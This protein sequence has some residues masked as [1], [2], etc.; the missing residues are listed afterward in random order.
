M[1]E[2]FDTWAIIWLLLWLAVCAAWAWIYNTKKQIK[3]TRKKNAALRAA[4]D[5]K[6]AELR[7]VKANAEAT[8]KSLAILQQSEAMEVLRKKLEASE[9][10]RRNL[11]VL[12]E[13]K[14][15]TAGACV[16]NGGES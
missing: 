14:W 1:L 6:T 11:E 3:A 4:L 15:K 10:E 9:R 13:Q 12:L 16:V 8:A 5:R 2:R 7:R